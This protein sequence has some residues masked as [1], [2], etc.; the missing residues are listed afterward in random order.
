MKRELARGSEKI[1]HHLCPRGFAEVKQ[2]L[3]P[4]DLSLTG[5]PYLRVWWGRLSLGASDFPGG[6]C[7]ASLVGHIRVFLCRDSCSQFADSVITQFVWFKVMGPLQLAVTWY[8]SAI[9]ESKLPTGTSRTKRLHQDKFAFSLFW[10]S[11]CVA[12]SPAASR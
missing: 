2:E 7:S 1:K 3:N 6:I 8:K 4:R 9:L 12:Y 11:Q 5:Q 10:M